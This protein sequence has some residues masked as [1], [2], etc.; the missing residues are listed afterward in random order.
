M[1]EILVTLA[2]TTIV[3][4]LFWIVGKFVGVLPRALNPPL[5]SARLPWIFSWIFRALAMM[6][7]CIVSLDRLMESQ[8]GSLA[9]ITNL[10]WL[11]LGTVLLFNVLRQAFVKNPLA[12]SFLGH[13]MP[14]KL[15][16]RPI[17]TD[18]ESEILAALQRGEKIEAIQRYREVT[19]AGLKEAKDFVEELM[20]RDTVD[21]SPVLR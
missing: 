1:D 17:D 16:A 3:L 21:E 9:F 14:E 20:A 2:A 19:G 10:L 18:T 12:I 13:R 7:F 6:A 8:S 11:V 4:G 15:P 5:P